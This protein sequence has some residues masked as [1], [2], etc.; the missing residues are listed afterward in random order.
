[1]EHG[2]LQQTVPR[3]A[4]RTC[5]ALNR[6][7]NCPRRLIHRLLQLP[8]HALRLPSVHGFLALLSQ[9]PR[10]ETIRPSLSFLSCEPF[11]DTSLGAPLQC[12][13]ASL[14]A[15]RNKTKSLNPTLLTNFSTL[16]GST[17]IV[18]TALRDEMEAGAPVRS[19]KGKPARQQQVTYHLSASKKQRWENLQTSESPRR[20]R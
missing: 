6:N 18:M 15:M 20:S 8:C 1:M 7:R 16:A 13:K 3:R 14:W 11:S 12:E 19:I 17:A 5:G 2:K 10:E 9:T 4:E